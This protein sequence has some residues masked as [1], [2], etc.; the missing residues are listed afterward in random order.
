MS[1]EIAECRSAAVPPPI[2]V[3]V[4]GSESSVDALRWAIDHAWLLESSVEAVT[5]WNQAE[6]IGLSLGGA[7]VPSDL[8]AG[9][10]VAERLLEDSIAATGCGQADSVRRRVVQGDP[11][12]TL[13]EASET[14]RL[15]VVG[16]GGH[17]VATRLFGGSVSQSCIR[18]A[19]CP[20]LVFPQVVSRR[21]DAVYVN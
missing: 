16:N 13:R 10:A 12:R 15:L 6:T 3:G 2:V 5:V 11:A 8:T 14:A 7:A 19:R 17:G 18:H 21:Q 4:D 9:I 20:V 1:D